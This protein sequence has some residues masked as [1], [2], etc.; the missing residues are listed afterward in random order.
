MITKS[1]FKNLKRG[2]V[3]SEGIIYPEVQLL[4]FYMCFCHFFNVNLTF[5]FTISSFNR[6][7]VWTSQALYEAGVKRK[8]TDVVTWIE[9]MSQRS[10][11]HLQKGELHT[12]HWRNKALFIQTA[13]YSANV[14]LTQWLTESNKNK[15]KRQT[16]PT[17]GQKTREL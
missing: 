14:K 15:T 8:G 17:I 7:P 10:V 6:P 2:L 1:T 3:S 13:H 11:P 4:V 5:F 16:R 12:Q 9:I